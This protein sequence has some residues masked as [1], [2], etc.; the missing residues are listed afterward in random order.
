MIILIDTMAERYGQLPSEVMSK[1][2][3]FD[4][5][6]ADTAIGYRNYLH[7][8]A[9]GKSTAYNPKDYTQEDLLNILHGK[10]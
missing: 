1:A 8:K 7:D 2:T 9:N 5:F 3:T 4:I 6:V 10:S